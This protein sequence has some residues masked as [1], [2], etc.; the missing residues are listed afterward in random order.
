MTVMLW[1]PA[2]YLKKQFTV[3]NVVIFAKFIVKSVVKNIKFVVIFVI[4]CHT[5]FAS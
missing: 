4:V 5:I 1:Q 2:I 3:K